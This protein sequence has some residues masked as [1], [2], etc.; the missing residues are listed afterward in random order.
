MTYPT[1]SVCM[2]DSNKTR[3]G[4]VAMSIIGYGIEGSRLTEQRR[5]KRI[6]KLIVK[7]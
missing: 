2:L 7:L 3:N 1:C 4:N 5:G 6:S